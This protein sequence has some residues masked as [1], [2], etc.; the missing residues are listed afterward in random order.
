M[1]LGRTLMETIFLIGP[2]YARGLGD[3]WQGTSH[4]SSSLLSNEKSQFVDFHRSKV[5]A[6][7]SLPLEIRN[8]EKEGEK[9]LSLSRKTTTMWELIKRFFCPN[10]TARRIYICR[11]FQRN[12][13]RERWWNQT[14][15]NHAIYLLLSQFSLFLVHPY[16]YTVHRMEYYSFFR[17]IKYYERYYFCL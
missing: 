14:F 11:L 9:K 1:I 2:I 15:L 16:F 12:K 3:S 13:T 5:L 10:F 17:S 4:Q 8:R 7:S 6:N